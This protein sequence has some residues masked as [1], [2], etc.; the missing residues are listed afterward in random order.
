MIR[1]KEFQISPELKKAWKNGIA[2]LAKAALEDFRSWPLYE[3][4]GEPWP[5]APHRFVRVA[6]LSAAVKG[7]KSSETQTLEEAANP[8]LRAMYMNL[9]TVLN[10]RQQFFF[11]DWDRVQGVVWKDTEKALAVLTKRL[12]FTPGDSDKGF[13]LY[14]PNTRFWQYTWEQMHPTAVEEPF[15]EHFV[16]I[17]R[18]GHMA[19]GLQGKDWKTCKFLYW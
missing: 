11:E 16:T 7:L 14:G 4:V 6:S 2:P 1:T 3:H 9:S 5:D 17:F 13:W 19:A 18:S 10:V 15:H 8:G 12:K